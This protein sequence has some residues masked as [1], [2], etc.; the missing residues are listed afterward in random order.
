M[1]AETIPTHVAPPPHRTGPQLNCSFRAMAKK[2]VKYFACCTQH[3]Q[4]EAVASFHPQKNEACRE[5][6][7][8]IKTHR[9]QTCSLAIQRHWKASP[10]PEA[11]LHIPR[12]KQPW[13]VLFPGCRALPGWKPITIQT[14]SPLLTQNSS[15]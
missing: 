15:F 10:E 8:S 1:L 7:R 11:N 3:A 14:S 2:Q 4:E 13:L 9:L 12:Q 5:Y 6:E